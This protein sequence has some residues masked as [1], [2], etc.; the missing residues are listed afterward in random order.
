MIEAEFNG[1]HQ[2]IL[3]GTISREEQ[4]LRTNQINDKLLSL[5]ADTGTPKLTRQSNKKLFLI[6]IPSAVI[7]LA[8]SYLV[9]SGTL[10][11]DCPSFDP[12][13]KN[14]VLLI[15]FENVGHEPAQ[16][17]IVL[18][19]RIEALSIKKQLSTSIEL[20]AA[21]SGLSINDALQ[22][23]EACNA[24][25]VIWGKYSNS[26]DSMRLILQYHFFEQ[27]EWS[28]MSELIALK[29]VTG[30]QAGKMFKGLEDAIMSLCSVIALRQNK[31]ALARK[32]LNK[33]AEKESIDR[34]ILEALNALEP[35][36]ELRGG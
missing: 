13:L 25:V 32:W 34:K 35:E 29:D 8:A 36:A 2:Q 33:V 30:I 4:Q 18:R 21:K 14:K 22:A 27:P 15:P 28:K 12:E 24:N 16:P 17:H 26:S 31:P 9:F 3:K 1:L 5:L 7:L 6:V 20:G 19:D 11:Q 10:Y 23:A